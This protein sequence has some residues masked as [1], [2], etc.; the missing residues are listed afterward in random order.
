MICLHIIKGISK[1]ISNLLNLELLSVDFI[2]NVIDSL[3]KLGDVHLTILEP[4]LSDLVLV[5]DAQDLLLELLLPLHGLLGGQ[6][7]L[8]HVLADHLEL[9]LD[10]LQLALSELC[11]LDGPL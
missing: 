2:F 3:V 8:L 4:S 9:L 7:E 10:A 1:L 5:L 11:P 6:F